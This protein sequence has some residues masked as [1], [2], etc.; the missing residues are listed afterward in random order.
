MKNLLI[1]SDPP[2]APGFLPRLRYLCDYLVRKGYG[3]TLLTEAY[4]PLTF[5]HA[6]P[7]EQ[8]PM[9]SGSTFDWFI[10]SVWTLFTDWHN[11]A[12]AR[13]CLSAINSRL[14]TF[15][16][17][18]CTTFNEFPLGAAHRIAKALRVPLICDI[19]DLDEQVDDSRYQY[20]HQSMLLMPFRHIYRAVHIRR[21]NKVLRTAQ[22]ITTVSPW[23][24]EFIDTHILK[25]SKIKSSVIYNGFD[26]AVFYPGNTKTD[27][28]RV[29]YIGSLAEWQKSAMI[30]VK[31]AIEQLNLQL[32]TLYIVF[33]QHTP[34]KSPVPFEQMG[35]A[36]RNSSI[37]LVLTD[38]HT[39]GMLTTKFYEALGCEKPVLCVPSDNGALAQMIDYTQAGIATSDKKAIMAFIEEKYTEWKAN[40]FTRQKT[41]HREQF[42]RETQCQRFEEI[43][44]TILS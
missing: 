44:N 34:D 27:I 6:Y 41:A 13:K 29:S 25:S 15:D 11:R 8:I 5:D 36:I 24:A 10:K 28:F 18:I 39:H 32:K 19:R 42:S 35:E 12:F 43:L 40:G 33:D 22:A 3:V 4:Q 14:S 21:R 20:H 2:A 37:M 17:V 1:I 23:H 7:I 16:A 38:T 31:I 26:P 9:Y 30:K